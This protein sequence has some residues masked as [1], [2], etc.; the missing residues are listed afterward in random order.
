M[1]HNGNKIPTESPSI[2]HD[3]YMTTGTFCAPL[4]H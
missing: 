4:E 2:C 3:A 1:P